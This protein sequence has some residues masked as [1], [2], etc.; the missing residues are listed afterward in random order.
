[1]RKVLAVVLAVPVVGFLY[2]A[3]LAHRT[4]AGRVLVAVG[5][6]AA[7]GLGVVALVPPRPITATPPSVV[8]P[9][10]AVAFDTTLTTGVGLRAPVVIRFAT[11]MDAASV[12]AALR[13]DPV[14]AVSLTWDPT[15]RALAVQPVERWSPGAL[16]A[17]TVDA[18]A[19]DAFG[20]PLTNAA[21]SIFVTREPVSG[22]IAGTTAAGS[23]L[24]LDAGFRV[25][26]D[27]PVD[28]ASAAAAFHIEPA[29]DGRL[30]PNGR[31]GGVTSFTFLPAAPLAADTVYRVWFEPTMVDVDGAAVTTPDALR[32]RTIVAPSV[33]RFRPKDGMAKVGRGADVSVRFTTAMQRSSTVK[34]FHVAVNGKAVPGRITWAEGD[35]V[36]V[37]DPANAFPYGATVVATID[38]TAQSRAGATLKASKGTFTVAPKPRPKPKARPEAATVTS[39]PI[40][41]PPSTGGGSVGSGSWGAVERYYL[42]LMNCTRTG[43]WVTSGGK[44]SS[45]G[46]RN[47]R[48]LKLDTGISARVS[49]PYAKL[50]ATRGICNHF[51]NG[52][53]GDRLRRAGYDSY[54]W[55]E[56]LGCRSGNAYGAVLGSHLYFQ[57]ERPYN[58]GHYVNLM[59]SAY[60]RV[61]IGV[62]VS[63]GRV[64][65]VIDFYHP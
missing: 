16:H 33:V 63:G 10:P 40:S 48:A 7:L 25:A 43:G 18:G 21:R 46:G 9:M 17:V 32:V 47:V 44:C 42:N 64:R 49:R 4:L 2:L 23:R 37:F 5:G 8:R 58:G 31:R 6:G 50:L 61:G 19:L 3:T 34:A 41:R 65:L 15:G 12:A 51:I 29:V 30:V 54:R 57:S 52:N 35:T 26:F 55:A 62:W 20:Q 59:N 24:T 14:T 28:V 22:T 38:A 11:P 13:V 45:P 60:D 53:P 36:L 39:R 1:L 56:N 27:A